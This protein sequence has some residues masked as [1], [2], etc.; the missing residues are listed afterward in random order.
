[1]SQR[2]KNTIDMMSNLSEER[3][4]E[5]NYGSSRAISRA[6]VST[7]W[8]ARNGMPRVSLPKRKLCK[9]SSGDVA[10]RVRCTM[11]IRIRK[12]APTADIRLHSAVR[13]K[14]ASIGH[15]PSCHASKS[16]QFVREELQRWGLCW[17]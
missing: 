12:P 14:A 10:L 1:M 5:E 4:D 8:K 17:E 7:D 9:T 16:I 6:G 3:S 11:V 2:D 13:S 15:W